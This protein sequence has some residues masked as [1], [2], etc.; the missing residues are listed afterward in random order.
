[1]TCLNISMMEMVERD[2]GKNTMP[3]VILK[4]FKFYIEQKQT[5]HLLFQ[6]KW[7]QTT[8]KSN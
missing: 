7:N 8:Q 4:G 5:Y 3:L 1:M 6:L 2:H